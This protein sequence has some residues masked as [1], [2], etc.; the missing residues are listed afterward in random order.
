M[1]ESSEQAASR[2]DNVAFEV[3]ALDNNSSAANSGGI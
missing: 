1:V 3:E 2:Q